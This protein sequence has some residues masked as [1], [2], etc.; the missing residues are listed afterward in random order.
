MITT[1][2]K[3]GTNITQGVPGFMEYQT[4]S[5][6]FIFQRLKRASSY[7]VPTCIVR[8]EHLLQA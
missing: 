7:T 4:H 3:Q 5:K 8:R 6:L 1:I 2:G